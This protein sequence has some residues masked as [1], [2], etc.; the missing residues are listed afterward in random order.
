METLAVFHKIGLVRLRHLFELK[1][2]NE[3]VKVVFVCW[4]LVIVKYP[5]DEPA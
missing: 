3:I 2:L 5:R 1:S 4:M